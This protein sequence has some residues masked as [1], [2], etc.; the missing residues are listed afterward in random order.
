MAEAPLLPDAGAFEGLCVAREALAILIRLHDREVDAPL[1]AGL[2]ALQ[3]GALFAAL[4]PS[5]TGQQAAR[6][7]QAGLDALPEAPDAAL[8][9]LLAV[10]Y[11][12]IY[13][14]NGHRISPQASVWLTEDGLERQEPMFEVRDWYAHY[15]I[16]VPDWRRRADDHVVHEL[17]FLDHLLGLQTPVALADAARFMDRCM[18]PWLPEMGARMAA[19]AET[20][21]YAATGL[22]TAELLVALRE[23]LTALTGEA[24]RP[25]PEPKALAADAG[26]AAGCSSEGPYLPG[27]AP[28]W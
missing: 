23:M 27:L 12:E 14:T 13:L 19:R 16:A 4:L 10:D 28:S 25:R 7:M 20:Q 17:Q 24:P 15:G 1:L 9:D 18:L 3:T 21:L 2:K 5:R 6:L 22:L 11:A 26:R 8:L